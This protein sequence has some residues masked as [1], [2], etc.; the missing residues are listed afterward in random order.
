M[1]SLNFFNPSYTKP[2]YSGGFQQYREDT[3]MGCVCE[4]K[5]VNI[6]TCTVTIF[7][8]SDPVKNGNYKLFAYSL[9]WYVCTQRF[10]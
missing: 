9:P 1:F 4:V 3:W 5:E 10:V 8:D 7:Q 6:D 2:Y